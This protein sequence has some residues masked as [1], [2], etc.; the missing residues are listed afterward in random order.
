MDCSR[1]R[2]LDFLDFQFLAT[3]F[4]LAKEIQEQSRKGDFSLFACLPM[5]K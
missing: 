2:F 4:G 3:E 5:R 1:S